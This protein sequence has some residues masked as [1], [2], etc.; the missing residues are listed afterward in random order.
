MWEIKFAMKTISNQPPKGTSDWLPAEYKIRKYIFDTW[1]K[2]CLK[3]GYQ[4]Y[5]T[6]ILESA[7]VY[8]AKSGEDI[9]GKELMTMVDRAGRELAI[10]PEMTPSVTRMVSKFYES[11][12]KP[13]RLFSIANFF[14]N[15]KPQ[16]GRNREFWQLNFDLFGS[17]SINADL[18]V[19]MIGLDIMLAFNPPKGSFTMYLN[20]RQLINEILKDVNQ[21]SDQTR[22]QILRTLDKYKKLTSTDFTQNLVNLGLNQ[23]HIQRLTQ[24]LEIK[25]ADQLV[26]IFP[27]IADNIGFKQIS[28]VL[29][30]LT[31]LGYQDWIK[32]DPGVIRGFDYYDGMVFEVFDNHPD[33][34]RSMF[35]GGRYN[36][37]ASIFGAQSFPATGMAPGD[38]TTKLFLE[39]WGLLE[40]VKNTTADLCYL[41]IL[42][43]NMQLDL[44]KLA[45]QLRNQGKSVVLGVEVEKIT[46][47]LNFANKNSFAE[48][49]IYGENEKS[50]QCYKLKDM[51]TGTEQT[52]AYS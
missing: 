38:E 3:Y 40:Q 2:V 13:L 45:Q 18:E 27:E 22:T 49:V 20:H 7:E 14:R 43:S 26:K 35:G 12:A 23:D 16:R 34:N 52:V 28:Q 29:T 6:P 46:K 11:V 30:I 21:L 24:I 51:Q 8:R 33:N 44:I 1:R 9:G 37:L 48:V 4:E 15:E 39:S 5:L 10:R 42:A 50:A 19:A 31:Q 41:P 36:G 47:A 32:F 17:D 25:D